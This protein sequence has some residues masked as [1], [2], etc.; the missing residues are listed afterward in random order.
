V[1]AVERG[2]E[3]V[4]L[5]FL[6]IGMEATPFSQRYLNPSFDSLKLRLG[7]MKFP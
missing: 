3:L 5:K 7:V 4:M 1:T 6:V 2:P